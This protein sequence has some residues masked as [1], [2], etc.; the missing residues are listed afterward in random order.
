ME[1]APL[2][3]DEGECEDSQLQT[4]SQQTA[5]GSKAKKKRKRGGVGDPPH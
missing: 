3:D 2:Q 4:T 5:S 1:D